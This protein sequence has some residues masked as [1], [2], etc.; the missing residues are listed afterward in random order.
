M[1]TRTDRWLKGAM[2]SGDA[3]VAAVLCWQM[4]IMSKR[5]VHRNLRHRKVGQAEKT[6]GGVGSWEG[7]RITGEQERLHFVVEK[8]VSLNV[9]GPVKFNY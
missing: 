5:Y 6:T 8:L 3:S 9:R 2:D 7:S 4:R 1:D